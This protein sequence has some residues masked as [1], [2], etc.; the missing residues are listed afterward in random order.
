MEIGLIFYPYRGVDW[1]FVLLGFRLGF[2]H[3]GTAINFYLHGG[4]KNRF[5][6]HA[7]FL[8]RFLLLSK[9]HFV[10]FGDPTLPVFRYAFPHYEMRYISD[11][12]KYEF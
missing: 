12:Q 2:N 10:F 4:A 5:P 3:I 9:S 11:R 6:R 7:V 8:L 1:A